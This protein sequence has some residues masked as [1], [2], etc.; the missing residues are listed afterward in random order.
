[1]RARDIMTPDVI[2]ADPDSPVEALA[3]LMLERR[4]SAI[5]VLDQDT[6]VGLVSEGDLLRRPELGTAPPPR[7][8]WLALFGLG[9]T[10]AAEIYTASHGRRAAEVMSRPV[11]SAGSDTPLASLQELMQRHHIKRVPIVDDGRLVGM[12]TRA[13]LLRALVL[14]LAAPAGQDDTAIR[15]ALLAEIARQPW[16]PGPG[17]VAVLV[18]DGTVHLAGAVADPAV[19]SAMIAAAEATPGVRGVVDEALVLRHPI[20]PM[21]RPHWFDRPPP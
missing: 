3:R 1:M 17:A 9:A 12:V 5:P 10:R 7:P 15:A 4:I 19:R 16:A 13:D 11:I 14:A 8:R 2:T 21:D 18:R 20:D 6:L